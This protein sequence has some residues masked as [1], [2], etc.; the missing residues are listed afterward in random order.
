LNGHREAKCH[1][2]WYDDE[3]SKLVFRRKLAK[4]QWLQDLSVVN[5]DNLSNGYQPITNLVKDEKGDLL[6]NPDK[7][8]N[9]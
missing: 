6:A 5:E 7:I 4:L 3:C 9:M 8:V 2:P 1:K